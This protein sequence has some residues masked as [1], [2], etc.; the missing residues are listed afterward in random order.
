MTGDDEGTAIC[1][2]L[3]GTLVQFTE[4][5]D[6]IV[7][8]TLREQL[9]ESTPDL[10]ETYSETF[11]ETFRALEPEPYRRGMEAVL[12]ATADPETDPD[13]MVAALQE[14]EY[15]ATE[16]PKAARSA[17]EQLSEEASLGIVTNGVPEWQ[18]GK[19][20]HH[21]VA[22]LFDAVVTSYEA[23]AHKPDS[24]PF[25]LARERIPAGGYAMVGDD[26]EADVEGARAAGFVP[27]HFEESEEGDPDFWETLSVML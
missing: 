22:D 4:P 12:D 27:V 25:E 8:R 5:F 20:E 3:D 18:A 10:V 24:A 19:L 14:Q 26:Y 1:F 16:F 2:D 6:E 21:G 17:V 15:A 11:I 13:A 7:A 23:G 9:D